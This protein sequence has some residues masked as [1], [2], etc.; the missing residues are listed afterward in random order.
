MVVLLC[1]LILLL[2]CFDSD[3][4]SDVCLIWCFGLQLSYPQNTRV[5][6]A[7]FRGVPVAPRQGKRCRRRTWR[8]PGCGKIGSPDE[9][10]RL[11]P[12]VGTPT[13]QI[14]VRIFLKGFLY[15][16]MPLG[17]EPPDPR[18]FP[19]FKGFFLWGVVWEWGSHSWRALEFP[20]NLESA[21]F[22]RW[23]IFWV[24]RLANFVAAQVNKYSEKAEKRKDYIYAAALIWD[25]NREA[26]LKWW[27]ILGF[28]ISQS[29]IWV[30]PKIGVPPNHPF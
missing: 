5:W 24:L 21:T 18:S 26:L 3:V 16:T 12:N 6:R 17:R 23:K 9:A 29:H 19:Y 2:F 28:W 13:G 25:Y 30:F 22:V 15:W 10:N 27:A 7:P 8:S 20:L 11:S 14:V 4:W 1:S